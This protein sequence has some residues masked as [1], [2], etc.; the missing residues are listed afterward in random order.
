MPA[1]IVINGSALRP[2][3][4][5]AVAHGARVVLGG[6]ARRAMLPSLHAFGDGT[7]V[8]EGKR[9]QLIGGPQVE[10]AAPEAFILSHCSA[11]G[12]ALPVPVARALILCRAN[13]LAV[14]ASGVRPETVQAMLDLLNSGLTPVIPSQGSVGAAGD[15]APL[16]HAAR[17]LCGLGGA[18]DLPD[19]RRV[20]RVDLG[21]WGLTA[22][23][24]TPK[25]ALSL[26]NG[27]TLTVALAAMAVHRAR[28]V[29]DALVT[30]CAMTM[31]A[32]RA[33]LR[34]LSPGG[35]ELRG[36]PGGV[37]VAAELR[38]LL[39]GSELAFAGRA[40]DPFSLRAAPAVLGALTEA[41][42]HVQAVVIRELNGACD[43][44]IWLEAEGVVE[45]GNF[46]GAPVALALDYLR[47]ALT[48]AV[49]QSERRTYRLC[50]GHLAGDLPSFLV[51]G[52]GLNSGLMLAQY[53]AASLASECKGLSHPAVVDSIP[54][55][56]HSEDHV[57]M[58]P[59]AGRLALRLLEN[60]ADIAAIEALFAAQALDFR[61]AGVR[62]RGPVREVEPPLAGAPGVEAARLR[63]REVVSFWEDDRI[64]E[65]TLSA[66]GALVRSG[67]LACGVGQMDPW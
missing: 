59:I 52:T 58:G 38:A 15:L 34:C 35:M 46:H 21:A 8:L 40:P 11:V 66:A 53:T 3:H 31:E 67:R 28:R 24:P 18:V 12:A 50:T 48:Q 36:H 60:T 42:D 49:T 37:A 57:S 16:A 45:V 54:T 10:G 14:G 64:L 63:V 29:R 7:A 62:F 4:V 33:D 44:P 23:K 9:R 13:V 55:V 47:A 19:G 17:V 56:Q 65:P 26:I 6:E 30:A 27:A 61:R 32:L 51:E 5:A 39:A 25:E 43:N 22:V 20:D 2:D 1:T 41:L